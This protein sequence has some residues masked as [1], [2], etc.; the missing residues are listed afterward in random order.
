MAQIFALT[1]FNS[2]VSMKSQRFLP[3]DHEIKWK[4][5]QLRVLSP[6]LLLKFARSGSFVINY[7]HL[8]HSHLPSPSLSPPIRLKMMRFPKFAVSLTL[9]SVLACVLVDVHANEEKK[10]IGTVIGI[11]LGTTYSWWVVVIDTVLQLLFLLNFFKSTR[12]LFI[13]EKCL[14]KHFFR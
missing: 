4:S 13:F 1:Q 14:R 12:M 5:Q 8:I 9:L 10:D 6:E 2:K 3:S 7:R 11:D